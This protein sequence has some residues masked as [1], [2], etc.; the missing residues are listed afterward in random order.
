MRRVAD[1]LVEVRISCG[2][3]CSASLYVSTQTGR[4]SEMFSDV[5]A[6]DSTRE[7]VAVPTPGGVAVYGL[8]EG[9]QPLTDVSLSLSP[10]AA[11]VSAFVRA[12]FL[13]DGSLR[14]V[15]LRGSEF[16]EATA[17]VPVPSESR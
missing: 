5:L 6:V 4:A 16:E 14:V 2:S 11:P 17:V 10:T 12:A 8:W 1:D 9:A 13:D 3:P 7:R 15:H